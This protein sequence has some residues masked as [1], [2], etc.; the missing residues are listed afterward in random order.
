M[1]RLRSGAVGSDHWSKANAEI[2]GIARHAESADAKILLF[3]KNLDGRRPAKFNVIFGANVGFSGIKQ[4]QNFLAVNRRFLR[5][6]ADNEVT[7]GERLEL[8][9]LVVEIHE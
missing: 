7:V 3:G 1:A 6:H 9:H 2:A 8:L 4:C 5:S